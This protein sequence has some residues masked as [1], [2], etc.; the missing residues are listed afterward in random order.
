MDG[1]IW[2]G[3]IWLRTQTMA[4]SCEHNNEPS[5]FHKILGTFWLAKQLMASQQGLSSMELVGRSVTPNLSLLLLLFKTALKVCIWGTGLRW[6]LI[7]PSLVNQYYGTKPIF[8]SLSILH[9][10][11][12]NCKNYL[13]IKII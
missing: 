6:K 7:L 3:F 2:P 5:Q 11:I 4:D 13:P 10:F 1:G 9:S 12:T 8:L